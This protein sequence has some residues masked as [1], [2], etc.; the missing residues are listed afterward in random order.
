MISYSSHLCPALAVE[1][2]EKPKAD[3]YKRVRRL[4]DGVGEGLAEERSPERLGVR[5]AGPGVDVELGRGLERGTK[6][7]KRLY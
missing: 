4:V 2:L 1:E 6:R 7:P 3:G 5:V